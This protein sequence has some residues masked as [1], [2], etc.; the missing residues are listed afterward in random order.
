MDFEITFR[1]YCT[2]L[3][4]T[5]LWKINFIVVRRYV[6]RFYVSTYC[7]SVSIIG[8]ENNNVDLFQSNNWKRS[9]NPTDRVGCKIIRNE[10]TI[11]SG[12][13]GIATV[14]VAESGFQQV[15][16]DKC[17]HENVS[18]PCWVAEFMKIYKHFYKL[19]LIHDSFYVYVRKSVRNIINSMK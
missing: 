14:G 17:N 4:R 16:K 10:D 18:F 8:S 15:K 11:V 12:K 6:G 9:H 13:R 3:Y 5:V 2:V 19:K 1:K 7:G